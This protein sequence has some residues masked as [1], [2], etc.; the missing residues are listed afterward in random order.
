MAPALQAYVHLAVE[1]FGLAR[2]PEI[3]KSFR[4]Q[5]HLRRCL[6]QLRHPAI[7]SVVRRWDALTHPFIARHLDAYYD[8]GTNRV[9]IN[10]F[11]L[12]MLCYIIR[13]NRGQIGGRI[14]EL[15]R[16]GSPGQPR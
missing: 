11:R 12:R 9:V 3:L 16:F 10:F 15:W 14:G 2:P 4:A 8:C 1:L 7:L 6:A 5:L 13:R